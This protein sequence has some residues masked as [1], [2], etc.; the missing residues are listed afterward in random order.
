MSLLSFIGHRLLGGVLGVF[1]FFLTA[2]SL[3]KGQMF[4]AFV[5]VILMIAA[6]YFFK[7]KHT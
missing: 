2:I 3:A 1:G 7:T 4:P 5:G 6:A